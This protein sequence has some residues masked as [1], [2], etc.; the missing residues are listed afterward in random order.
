MAKAK[1]STESKKVV[2]NIYNSHIAIILIK[3]IF[4]LIIK[5][6]KIGKRCYRNFVSQCS[7]E[8]NHSRCATFSG[9]HVDR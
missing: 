4:I 1:G 8:N 5:N 7:D 3:L 9:L 2:F 6:I